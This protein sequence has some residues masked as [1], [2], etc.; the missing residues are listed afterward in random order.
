MF[1]FVALVLNG[2]TTIDGTNM[3]SLDILREILHVIGNLQ[4]KLT[5]R[6]NNDS[7]CDTA[8]RVNALNQRNAESRC[9]T[10]ASLGKGN[11]I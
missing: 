11:K 5:G 1:Q 2:S 10:R 8:C 7:L 9:L 4:A 3:Q 6:S